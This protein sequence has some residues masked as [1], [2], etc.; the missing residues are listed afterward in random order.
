MKTTLM[1]HTLIM[2]AGLAALTLSAASMAQEPLKVGIAAEPYPP[3]SYKSSNGDWTGFEVELSKALCEEMQTQCEITPTGWSGIFPALNSGKIDMI[4]NSLSI[5]DKRRRVIDFTDPYYYTPA[6]YVAAKDADFEI[7]EGLDGKVLGVQGATTNATYARRE[8][9]D[10]GVELKIYD[11]QEQV[12]RDLLAGRIDVMLADEIVMTA[13]VERDEAQGY[14]IIATAPKH[15]A[16]GEGI[17]IGLRKS[18]DELESKLNDAIAAV[19]ENGRCSEL[20]QQY[21]G[22]DICGG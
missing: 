2:A 10:S 7:P 16:F 14:A 6:A 15:E 17:G 3:F 11:Q 1:K 4:M 8:L 22:T 20:S 13:F 21:F 19:V 9:R 5:T 18:D 12:N